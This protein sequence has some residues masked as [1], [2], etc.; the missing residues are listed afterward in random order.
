[1]PLSG[2]SEAFFCNSGCRANGAA[3]KLARFYGH[4]QGS[5]V[6]PSSSWK[7]PS[8]AARWRP[9]RP[10]ATARH[11]RVSS[12][13]S[14]DSCVSR[15]MILLPFAPVA[16]PKRVVAVMLE[17]VQGEGGINIASDEFQRDAQAVRRAGL[18]VD[19]DSA[20]RHGRTGKWFG[21]QHAGIVPD[22]MT[23]ARAG[24]RRADRRLPDRRQGAGLFKPGNHG[25]TFGGNPLACTAALTTST[26]EGQPDGACRGGRLGDPSGHEG[27]ARRCAVASSTSAARV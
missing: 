17:M 12:R 4:Q 15:T 11:K 3:I 9:C 21:F 6:P 8:T 5:T 18:A 27:R 2:M 14:P 7:R 22:V 25:S 1:M 16:Q 26:I 19:C 23:L 24:L 13:S 20:V 10:P